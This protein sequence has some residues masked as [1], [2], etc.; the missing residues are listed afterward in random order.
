ML[1]TRQGQPADV[2]SIVLGIVLFASPRA[3][4]FVTSPVAAWNAWISASVLIGVAVPTFISPVECGY[5]IEIM[6]GL[7][8][9]LSPRIIGYTNIDPAYEIH[10]AVGLSITGLALWRLYRTRGGHNNH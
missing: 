10:T 5:W 2:I 6:L 7:W 9:L 8:I 1:N 4:E 3:F